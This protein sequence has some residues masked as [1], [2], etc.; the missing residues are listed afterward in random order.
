MNTDQQELLAK[1]PEDGTAVGNVTLKQELGWPEEKYWA[2]R[3]SLIAKDILLLGRGRGGSVRRAVTAIP[4][5][6]KEEPAKVA[7]EPADGVTAEKV[8]ER[9][10][11]SQ[12]YGPAIAVLGSKWSRDLLLE[13]FF[14]QETAGQ[15]RRETGGTWTRPDV[16]VIYVTSYQHLP[17]KILD[18]VTFEIKPIETADVTA[19]YEALA[20]LRAAT[21]AFVL[22]VAPDPDQPLVAQALEAIADEASRHGVGLIVARDIN[23]YGTW[24]FR[25]DAERKEPNPSRLDEFIETQIGESN[26]QCLRKWIK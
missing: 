17:G 8:E 15:G 25:V 7:T 5:K 24:D 3:D 4:E 16:V 2:V 23:D 11:E 14:V 22:I 12:L 26:K 6:A 13:Q 20:H 9:K 21:Q 1:V 18:V 19:V 10:R